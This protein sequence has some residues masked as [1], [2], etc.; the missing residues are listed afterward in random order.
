MYFIPEIGLL[1]PVVRRMTDERRRLE[2]D[3]AAVLFVRARAHMFEGQTIAVPHIHNRAGAADVAASR[4][5]PY[6]QPVEFRVEHL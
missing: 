3:V 5:V 1:A 2:T 6:G 4:A